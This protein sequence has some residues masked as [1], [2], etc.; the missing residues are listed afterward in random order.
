MELGLEAKSFVVGGASGGLGQAVAERLVAEGA[1]VLLV[2]RSAETLRDLARELGER[3]DVCA[4]DL[5][6]PAGVDEVAEAAARWAG[7]TGSWSTR[8]VRPSDRHSI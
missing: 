6:V 1:R 4:A 3:A 7:S 5:S 2:A 8:G